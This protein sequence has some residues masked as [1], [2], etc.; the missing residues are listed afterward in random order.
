MN[1]LHD[2]AAEYAAAKEAE[3]QWA[4]RRRELAVA[5]QAATGHDSEGQKTYDAEP[6]LQRVAEM[7]ARNEGKRWG[8]GKEVGVLPPWVHHEIN[9]IRD[10]E[11]RVVKVLSPHGD[12]AAEVVDTLS[13]VG[14]ALLV[15]IGK[16]DKARK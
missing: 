13:E 5:I 9:M 14:A 7:R 11:E 3:A 1:T 4:T 16:L 15:A 2:L 12:G 8:D 6:Y 10:D